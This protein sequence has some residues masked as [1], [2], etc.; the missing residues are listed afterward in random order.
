MADWAANKGLEAMVI[1]EP[2]HTAGNTID[3]LLSNIP[4][5]EAGTEAELY[6][7]SDHFTILATIP[8]TTSPA[9]QPGRFRVPEAKIPDFVQICHL[10]APTVT[11]RADTVD[12]L[13]KLAHQ[14]HQAL[15]LALGATGAQQRNRGHATSWWTPECT[16]THHDLKRAMKERE[17]PELIRELRKNLRKSVQRAKRTY[18]ETKIA[19]AKSDK[20]LFT[21]T[22]WHKLTD[23]F[24][25]PPLAGPDG[26]ITDTEE[27]IRLL[28][29]KVP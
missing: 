17:H 2:T 7:G 28:R 10:A 13:E 3:Q 23:K 29:S 1:G 20:D 4:G 24:R 18:W 27:K 9:P 19:N 21:I 16:D 5:C 14:L 8:C 11:A 12:E 15:T 25:A 22:G 6:S 26:P